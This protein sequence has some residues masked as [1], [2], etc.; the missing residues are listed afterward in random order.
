MMRTKAGWLRGI[1]VA[2]LALGALAARDAHAQNLR[3]FGGA[4]LLGGTHPV[5]FEPDWTGARDQAANRLTTAAI[6]NDTNAFKTLMIV[7]NESAGMG[8][9][10]S[11]W[12]RLEV[13]GF[14][15]TNGASNFTRSGLWEC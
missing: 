8:R 11:V 15:Q 1:S 9:R 4:T 12:D 14:L 3:V 2:V 7:G 5:L 10:V 13:N 6:A